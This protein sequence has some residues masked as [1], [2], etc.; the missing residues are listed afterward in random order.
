MK[1]EGIQEIISRGVRA[2]APLI[3]FTISIEITGQLLGM[4]NKLF[5]VFRR[6]VGIQSHLFEGVCIV[7]EKGVACRVW[8]GI[9]LP[10]IGESL[11][12]PFEY[13]LHFFFAHKPIQCEQ[14]A[15][16]SELRDAIPIG[17]FGSIGCGACGDGGG[18]FL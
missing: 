4:G 6:L 10:L 15:A 9:E 14:L 7:I 17:Y 1:D 5:P 12:Y 2:E 16:F 11:T 13:I 18:D 3:D 8:N